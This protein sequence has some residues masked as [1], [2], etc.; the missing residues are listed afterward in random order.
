MNKE[1]LNMLKTFIEVGISPLLVPSSWEDFFE[2]AVV[3][4]ADISREYL[5][6][7]YEQEKFCPPDWYQ[8]LMTKSKKGRP[9]LIIKNINEI[10]VKEQ[11][12]FLE[13]LKYKKISTFNLPDNTVIIVTV[14]DLHK[15]KLADEVYSL[16]AQ[17]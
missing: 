4:K 10:D 5:N 3:L 11:T 9:L 8:E 6:G 2:N 16:L 12:K 14:T 7:Y 13:I 15:K 1:R 17:I